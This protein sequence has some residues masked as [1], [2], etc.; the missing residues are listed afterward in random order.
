MIFG[1]W[2]CIDDIQIKFEFC[3]HYHTFKRV[4]PYSHKL[5]FDVY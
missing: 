5:D 2:L 3:L 4:V 1:M